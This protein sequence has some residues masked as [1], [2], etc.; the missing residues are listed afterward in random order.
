MTDTD[1]DTEISSFTISGEYNTA[2]VHGDRSLFDQNCIDQIRKLVDHEAFVGDESI[3]IMPDAHYGAGA[4]IGFTMPVRDRI[5]PNVVGVDI[6]CGMYAVQLDTPEFDH[7]V[8]VASSTDGFTHSF[9]PSSKN[10]YDDET[11]AAIDIAIRDRVPVGFDVHDRA[12][13]H[14]LNDFPWSTWADTLDTFDRNTEQTFDLPGGSSVYTDSYFG[15]LCQRVGYDRGRAINSMGTL[16]SSNHLIE[17]G[18][19][20]DGDVWCIIHSGSRGIGAAIAEHWQERAT[21]AV[22][23]R[24]SIDDVP[25]PVRYYMDE[26]WSPKTEQIRSDFEGE[27][28]Q[29]AFDAV[30]Q[31]IQQY[32]PSTSDRN[33]DLDYLQGDEATGYIIDMIFAQTYA[34][35]SR[36]Q[37]AKSV[38]DAL[39]SVVDD[40]VTIDDSIESVHNYIDCDDTVIRKGACRAHDSER[41]IVPFNFDDGTLLCCGTGNDEWNNSS[42]HGAGRAMS[43]SA[44]YDRF[45]RDDFDEQVD[46][47]YMSAHP[48]DEL[49]ESYKDPERIEAAL[50]PSV[51]VIDRID[52]FLSI[53]AE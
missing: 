43:R 31:A 10:D 25:A 11:L 21:N 22:T 19:D 6:S 18:T 27:T 32:G 33:T 48:V 1:T 46:D 44:A 26:D 20:G 24:R 12:D 29:S 2:T 53:K 7:D 49:P 41:L 30:S 5:V 51:D 50:G 38:R 23:T 13:Y 16:G 34:S 35:E 3:A 15:D 36:S 14:M 4:V 39:C 37:M 47:V 45:D 8:A 52:P 42:A 17:L 28:I 9:S 40:T